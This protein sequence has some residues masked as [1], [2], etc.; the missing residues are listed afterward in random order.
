MRTNELNCKNA[1]RESLDNLVERFSRIQNTCNRVPYGFRFYFLGIF[2]RLHLLLVRPV[3]HR[4]RF[5]ASI[6]VCAVRS[7][8]D[9][10]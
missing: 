2:V 7:S 5:A 10:A 9:T 1:D 4:S 6:E 8:L 3:R